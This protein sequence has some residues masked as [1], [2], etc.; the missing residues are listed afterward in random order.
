MAE[1]WSISTNKGGVLKT[2]LT[3]NIAGLLSKQGHKV[4]IIDTDNQGN[5]ALSF[6]QNPDNY[7][8]TLYDVMVDKVP[9]RDAIVNVYENIDILPSND[10]MSFIDIDVLTEPQKHPKPFLLIKEACDELR[11]EYDYILLDT[12]PNI[13]LIQGNVLT[14]TDKVIIPFQPETY[15]QRSLIKMLTAIEKFKKHNPNLAV[16]GVVATLVDY[17]TTLHVEMIKKL[18]ELCLQKDIKCYTTVIPRTIRFASNVAFDLKPATLTPKNSE[19]IE[20]YEELLKEI[21]GA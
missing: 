4:L 2:S 18:K 17:R 11:N 8:M 19:Q 3:T 10:D 5:V 7:E 14:F 21:K 6:G 20:I 1:V 16:L 15:S 12:P 9:V 13:G